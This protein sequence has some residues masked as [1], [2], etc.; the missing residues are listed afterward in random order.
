MILL[1]IVKSILKMWFEAGGRVYC[2]VSGL[3]WY[4]TAPYYT[5]LYINRIILLDL[6]MHADFLGF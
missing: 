2:F 1:G 4:V 3:E 5:R 6:R